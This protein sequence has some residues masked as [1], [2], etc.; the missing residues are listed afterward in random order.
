M[1][2]PAD[3]NE[4]LQF[5]LLSSP[6]DELINQGRSGFLTVPRRPFGRIETPNFLAIT[7]RGTLNHVTPDILQEHLELSGIH[8]ALEDCES[9]FSPWTCLITS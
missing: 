1:S 3:N 6:D 8:L 9:L 2:L 7:S 4:Q 5:N